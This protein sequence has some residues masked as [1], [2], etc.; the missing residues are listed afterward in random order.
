MRIKLAQKTGKYENSSQ[1]NKHYHSANVVNCVAKI[2]KKFK[3]NKEVLVLA[4]TQSG[5]TEV[6]N[7]IA[8]LNEKYKGSIKKSFGLHFKKIYLIVCGSSNELKDDLIDKTQNFEIEI[9]H[10]NDIQK[11]INNYEKHLNDFNSMNKNALIIFDECHAVAEINQT[12]CKLR[13]FLDMLPG[14]IEDNTVR[15][16][17]ISATSYEHVASQIPTVILEPGRGYYGIKEMVD[18][19][20][21][22]DAK[23]LTAYDNVTEFVNIIMALKNRKKYVLIRMPKNKNEHQ[24]VKTNITKCMRK[25]TIS[26]QF[27][28]YNMNSKFELNDKY[29]NSKPNVTT[30][31]LIK[32]MLRMGK[33][34]NTKHV[35]LMYDTHDN[36]HTHTT[37][38]SFIGRASGY[39][40]RNH[41]VTVYCDLEKIEQH[42]KWIESKYSIENI[43]D[44][45]KY[46]D[47]NKQVKK[48]HYNSFHEVVVS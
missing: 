44:D 40:K 4:K 19:N 11:M 38:Q 34:V 32:D 5:K 26:F 9:L 1:A 16:L 27:K 13:D 35:C 12:V 14:N 23:D 30:V 47:K 28:D 7:R 36:S 29:L 24:I 43:P 3:N 21:V 45:S 41:G 6:C 2:Y 22:K 18:L 46:C 20:R 17:N 10:I 15:I 31:I 33:T 25:N 37:V 48:K 39:N 42:L 8:E